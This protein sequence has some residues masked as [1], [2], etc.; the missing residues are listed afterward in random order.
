MIAD[1]RG[2]LLVLFSISYPSPSQRD[3]LYRSVVIFGQCIQ[4][5]QLGRGIITPVV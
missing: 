2:Q 5:E 3:I 1:R 4:H